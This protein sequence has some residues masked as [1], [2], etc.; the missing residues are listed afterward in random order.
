MKVT[1]HHIVQQ[2]E[3]LAERCTKLAETLSDSGRPLDHEEVSLVRQ[4]MFGWVKEILVEIQMYYLMGEH[5]RCVMAQDRLGEV[6]E[7]LTRV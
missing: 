7:A 4:A 1:Q 2:L 6:M 5:E 3:S